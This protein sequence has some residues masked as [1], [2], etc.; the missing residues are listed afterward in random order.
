MFHLT[1]VRNVGYAVVGRKHFP[2]DRPRVSAPPGLGVQRSA[3]GGG[4][5]EHNQV[6]KVGHS[7]VRSIKDDVHA[8]EV[9]F[10]I[11]NPIL[12]S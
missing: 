12:M 1:C 7:I 9:E 2:S 8:A 3:V 11:R 6:G 4:R 5:P 10:L